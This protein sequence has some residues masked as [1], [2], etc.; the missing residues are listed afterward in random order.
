MPK[1]I[2]LPHDILIPGGKTVDA[3]I[4]ETILDVALRNGIQIE[5]ACEKSCACA[6]CHCVVRAGFNSLSPMMENEDDVLDKAWGV[7][8]QSRLSCQAYINSED[9]VVEIPQYTINII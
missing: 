7:K 6:T 3:Q 5:H 8:P 1:I 9:L 2:F 4:G